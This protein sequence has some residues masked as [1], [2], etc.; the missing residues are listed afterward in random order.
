[1]LILADD[2]GF[3]DV[4]AYG[5]RKVR[6]PNLDRMAAEGMRFTQAYAGSSLDIPSLA[7]LLTGLHTGHSPIRAQ[8]TPLVPLQTNGLTL[9]AL[10]KRAGY[11]TGLIGKWGLGT[12]NTTGTPHRQHYDEWLGF[13]TPAHAED[14]FT[15]FLWR[16]SANDKR[17]D[18][19][20]TLDPN[21]DDRQELYV[22]DYLTMAATNFIRISKYQ[23]FFL[24]LAFTLPH[25]NS[26]L[27]QATGNGMQVPNDAPYSGQDWPAPDKN[28]AAMIHRLDR[29]VGLV[30]KQLAREKLET[31][32]LVLF[33]SDNGPS[34]EGGVD[35]DLFQS[36]G[37]FQGVKGTLGEGALRV[38]LIARWPGRVKAGTTNE[39]L[40]AFWDVLPTAAEIAGIPP[41]PGLDGRS[42][43]ASLANPIRTNRHEYL[44]W[45]LHGDLFQQALRMDSW[46]AI[47]PGMDQPILL[48]DLALDPGEQTNRAAMHP[49]LA[50]RAQTLMQTA[51]WPSRLWPVPALDS[52]HR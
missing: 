43:A 39:S 4:G 21:A 23:P 35:L 9:A 19:V 16:S 28:R 18:V 52:Q 34:P 12:E 49:E 36:T 2:L 29:S 27:A 41:P 40:I 44:Y 31:N 47:R 48:Y 10:L 30:L 32:T 13:L 38:P 17:F 42:F 33:T 37:P 51:R 1:M 22:H 3:G 14:A 45:E 6:T 7:S 50:R 8:R 15:H 5:Q 46:K 25:A 20:L 11:Q 26:Q 24:H